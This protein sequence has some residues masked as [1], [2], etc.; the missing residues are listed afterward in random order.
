MEGYHPGDPGLD[1]L[2]QFRGQSPMTAPGRH[3]ALFKTVPLDLS[4]M[5]Q[6]VHG[7]LIHEYA[8]GQYG[9]DI[10][11]ERTS[12]KHLRRLEEMLDR[13]LALDGRPLA[14]QRS[15]NRR[16]A[17]VCRHFSVMLV[18]LLR[19]AGIPARARCGFGSYFHFG[20]YEDHWVA[21]YW[22]PEESRWVMVDAQLDDTWRAMLQP[23]FDPMDVPH[24]RFIV[25]GDAWVR[26]RTGA[27]DPN[28][29]GIFDKRGL[30]FVAGNVLRDLASV[31]GMEMLPWDSWGPMPDPQTPI[32]DEQLALFDRIAAARRSPAAEAVALYERDERLRVPPRV[33][34]A[35]LDRVE[36][37]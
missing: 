23:D 13:L 2:T 3:A 22:R 16:L 9:V 26:C 34:N 21:E 31:S 19:H 12:E 7:A 1:L 28:R 10:P 27:S 11:P 33:F 20:S 36:T 32:T 18:A 25:A 30:W 37:V 29:F 5:T 4:G 24:D 17:G 14:E 6:L 8:A 35:V 15:P